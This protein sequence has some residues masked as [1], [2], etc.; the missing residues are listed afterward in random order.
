MKLDG[1]LICSKCNNLTVEYEDYCGGTSYYRCK[2]CNHWGSKD[3]FNE[4]TLFNTITVSP[5]VLSEKFVY[6]ERPESFCECASWRSVILGD[7]SFAKREEAI[8][9]TLEKLMEV[10]S[11]HLSKV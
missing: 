4:A 8:K 9:A 5:D 3:E 10:H 7:I 11:E 6:C 1:K 2:T